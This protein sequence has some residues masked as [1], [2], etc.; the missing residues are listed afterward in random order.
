[1]VV[2]AVQFF[3][4]R[5]SREVERSERIARHDELHQ[6]GCIRQGEFGQAVVGCVEH[7]DGLRGGDG[8]CRTLYGDGLLLT[9]E[10]HCARAATIPSELRLHT[11]VEGNGQGLT[12]SLVSAK[13]HLIRLGRC[14][15]QCCAQCHEERFLV[16]DYRFN[17]I[18]N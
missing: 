10:G 13:R 11:S 15:Q 7:G 17:S 3:Q 5:H 9:S 1:M 16:H 2:R 4:H 12:G 18:R 14:C 8:E 6:V